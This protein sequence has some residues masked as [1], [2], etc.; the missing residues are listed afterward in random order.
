MNLKSGQ[1]QTW[2]AS[3]KRL[4]DA[5]YADGV[6]LSGAAA[7]RARK[8]RLAQEKR[9]QLA[10][11]G[12]QQDASD[13]RDEECSLHTQNGIFNWAEFHGD[14][15]VMGQP[16]PVNV[17]MWSDGDVSMKA[18]KFKVY[19]MVTAFAELTPQAANAIASRFIRARIAQRGLSMKLGKLSMQC[20]SGS[21]MGF[22]LKG[23]VTG[24]R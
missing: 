23:T 8:N 3:G 24:T 11:K 7:S 12:D 9:L 1:W 22:V 14:V 15:D 21:H 17:G 13:T 5:E 16:A 20:A 19:V 4:R 2:D 18:R 6:E 10:E